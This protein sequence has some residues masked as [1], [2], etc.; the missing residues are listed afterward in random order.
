MRVC[1]IQVG[2]LDNGAVSDVVLAVHVLLQGLEIGYRSHRAVRAGGVCLL[3]ASHDCSRG[4]HR[5]GRSANQVDQT[6]V[7]THGL[8]NIR[9]TP[10]D[11]LPG[12][13]SSQIRPYLDE[14]PSLC[15]KK[16]LSS[17]KY[18]NIQY[19]KEN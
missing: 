5:G 17:Q 2:V 11:R 15:A 6:S 8:V 1:S 9:K 3:A 13:T 4:G 18:A 16:Y 19:K 10:T 7:T 12:K 14:N